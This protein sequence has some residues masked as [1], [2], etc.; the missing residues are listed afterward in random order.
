MR[1][2]NTVIICPE[3]GLDSSDK[4]MKK[5]I[6]V[7]SGTVNDQQLSFISKPKVEWWK[8]AVTQRVHLFFV[9][10]AQSGPKHSQANLL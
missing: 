6:M 8:V 3:S 7:T 1:R 5:N 10:S 9:V 4:I 2:D